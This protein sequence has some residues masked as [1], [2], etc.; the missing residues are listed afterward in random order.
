M[1]FLSRRRRRPE[2]LD[3]PG[4]APARHAHALRGLARINLLSGSARILWP[5]LLALGE[6]LRPGPL[7]LL[8]VA[9]GAGDVP[10]RLW[11][12]ARAAGLDWQISGCDL[13]PVAVDHARERAA[14]GGAAVTFFTHDA[15]NGPPLTG[16]DAVTCSLFL[17]HLDDEDAVRLLRRMAGLGDAPPSSGPHLVLVNDL[18]RSLTGWALA[19]VGTR[20]LSTSG[21]V[22]TDGPLS[23]EGAYTPEEARALAER[24]GLH[25]ARVVRRWPCRFLLSWSRP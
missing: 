8:D 7:R 10:I 15:L 4:L 1:A 13:S 22:H 20:L 24:A 3:Q 11:R 17:H 19:Y 14:R 18:A 5:P 9:T 23:V 6:R 21:V 12:R 16:Y 2:L 25:G